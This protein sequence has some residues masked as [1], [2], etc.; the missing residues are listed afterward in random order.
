MKIK[1][2]KEKDIITVF[3]SGTIDIPSAENLKTSLSGLL[4]DNFKELVLDFNELKSIGSSGIGA[5][6]LTHKEFTSRGI[7]FTVINVNKEIKALF[8]LIRL[9][10]LFNM[11]T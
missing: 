3:L 4:K 2:I 5:L 7:S 6:L 9:D 11:N 8:K 1:V 10:K